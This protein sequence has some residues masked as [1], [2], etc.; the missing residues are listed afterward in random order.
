MSSLRVRTKNK[1]MTA[2]GAAKPSINVAF[3]LAYSDFESTLQRLETLDS[4]LGNYAASI[5]TF[6]SAASLVV[7]AIDGLSS[8][9]S[10]TASYQQKSVGVSEMQQLASEARVTCIDM[11]MMVLRETCDRLEKE[12]LTPVKS[13]LQHARGLQNEAKAFQEKKALYDH[14]SRKMMALRETHEKRAKT[15]RNGK[16]KDIERLIRNE[17][18]LAVTTQ[19]YLRQSDTVIRGLRAFVVSRDAALALLLRRVLRGR[20]IYAERMHEAT[21]FINALIEDSAKEGENDDGILSQYLTAVE[22]GGRVGS[23]ATIAAT[24]SPRSTYGTVHKSSCE[25]FGDEVPLHAS[26]HHITH[27]SASESSPE[28]DKQMPL[29]TNEGKSLYRS[30]CGIPK[31]MT[32]NM[33]TDAIANRCLRDKFT[34]PMFS[35]I[36]ANALSPSRMAMAPSASLSRVTT[37]KFWNAFSEASAPSV[38]PFTSGGWSSGR[39]AS[40]QHQQVPVASFQDMHMNALSGETSFFR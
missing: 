35:K 14:Y 9:G 10:G 19:G 27:I 29:S 24:L 31:L 18:K 11:D 36:P 32:A 30:P 21:G 38:D 39:Q 40:W 1:L 16:T 37:T 5:K 22:D 4:A 25:A 34:A 28:N 15:G 23:A 13:W 26:A 2:L 33:P 20:A 12:V 3:D 8:G 17:Q 6:H 7:D